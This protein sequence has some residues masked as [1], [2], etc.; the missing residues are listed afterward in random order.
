METP[1]RSP[2]RLNA[3]LQ[4]SGIGFQMLGAIAFCGWLG[5]WADGKIGTE[6]P[7]FLL[8]GML[9]GVVASIFVAIKSLKEL[10]RRQ[11]GKP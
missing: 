1:R 10:E 5:H 8:A 11:S 4:Y 2:Q 9:F 6:R 7:W 3:F